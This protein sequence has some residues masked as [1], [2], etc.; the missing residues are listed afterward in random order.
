MKIK[1]S[2]VVHWVL[3]LLMLCGMYCINAISAILGIA[4]IL[5]SLTLGFLSAR[6]NPKDFLDSRMSIFD[7]LICIYAILGLIWYEKNFD[8]NFDS[9]L[10][11]FFFAL[12]VLDLVQ[13]ITAYVHEGMFRKS[14][15][16][17]DKC[18]MTAVVLGWTSLLLLVSSI[19]MACTRYDIYSYIFSGTSLIS[20]FILL[21]I[22]ITSNYRIHSVRMQMRFSITWLI[23]YPLL[24][25]IANLTMEGLSLTFNILFLSVLVLD[26]FR[27]MMEKYTRH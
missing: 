15:K 26:F 1:Q 13:T 2:I 8:S 12:I 17:T 3:F 22:L 7:K 9:T 21:W 24:L 27:F 11:W 4:L 10:L 25:I 16:N 23:M 20:A 5:I 19:Y 14:T 18:I 6:H